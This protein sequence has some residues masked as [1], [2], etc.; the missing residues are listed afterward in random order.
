LSCTFD[1]DQQPSVIG[2]A[3]HDTDGQVESVA[4]IPNGTSDQVWMLVRRVINGAPVRYIER[5]DESL[6]PVHPTVSTSAPIYGATM[7][8]CMIFD[9]AAGLT[10]A[11]VPHLAGKTVDILLDGARQPRQTVP[12]G[13]ALTFARS[14]K[15]AIV[16]IP[17]RSEATLLTPEFNPGD[18]S[19]QG[20]SHRTGQL[21]T[22]FLDTVGGSVVNNVGG[23]QEIPSRQFGP[24]VLGQP[25]EPF[26]G[27]LR[28]SMLGW[29]RGDSEIG[30]VQ[31]G[32]YPMHLLS[33]MR[34]HTAQG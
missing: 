3:I 18:G 32:P 29:D 9:N 11:S 2:W 20:Q 24:A 16:G 5:G 28:T 17:F 19:V 27:V 34:V 13:G 25:P 23:Q 8:C 31:D 6:V 14:A 7:D 33:V 26:T 10:T 30:V 4:T 22:R 12:A 21:V 1:R 15:R